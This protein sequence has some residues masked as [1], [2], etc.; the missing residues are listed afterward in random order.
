MKKIQL[1]E[2][3]LKRMITKV[4]EQMNAPSNTGGSG[5]SIEE[6]KQMFNSHID[7]IYN[8]IGDV[9]N[10]YQALS[11]ETVDNPR[12]KEYLMDVVS[13]ELEQLGVGP[14]E[15]MYSDYDDN[16]PIYVDDDDDQTIDVD[17][18][19]VDDEDNV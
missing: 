6:Y 10:L 3:E 5:T 17:H 12:E 11:K 4:M 18:T 13:G 7:D 1:T 9:I 19:E 15:Y 16:H 14:Y 2:N 8:S